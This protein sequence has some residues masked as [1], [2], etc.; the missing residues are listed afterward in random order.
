MS[1]QTDTSED[2]PGRTAL[3]DR[4][5]T[6]WRRSWFLSLP[7][8]GAVLVVVIATFQGVLPVN[9]AI[10]G[11]D[12][13][14]SSEGGVVDRGMQAYPGTYEAWGG[15]RFAVISKIPH[16]VLDNGLCFSL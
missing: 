1:T 10:A 12:F 9:V 4:G 6:R 3:F 15:K 2:V 7:S 16:A 5:V 14:V 13:K 8:F 11:I